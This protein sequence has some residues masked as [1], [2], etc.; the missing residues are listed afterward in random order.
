MDL[1]IGNLRSVGR[2]QYHYANTHTFANTRN[3]RYSNT[4]LLR[5]CR[6]KLLK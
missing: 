4:R 2:F 1:R 6:N 5:K 3:R